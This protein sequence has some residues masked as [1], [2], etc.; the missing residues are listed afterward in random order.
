MDANR[1]VVGRRL[2]WVARLSAFK[3]QAVLGYPVSLVLSCLGNP[4]LL[5][6]LALGRAGA[7]LVTYW[8][9]RVQVL[10]LTSKGLDH[11]SLS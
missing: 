10:D 6:Y 8:T 5:V 11:V 3:H 9:S 4:S 1:G 7:K 2:R